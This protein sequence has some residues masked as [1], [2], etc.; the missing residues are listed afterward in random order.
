MF[1]PLRE[2]GC[3]LK[4]TVRWIQIQSLGFSDSSTSTDDEA[5]LLENKE[6]FDSQDL[7]NQP[8]SETRPSKLRL[9]F[10]ITANVVSTVSIVSILRSS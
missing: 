4:G 1:A 3:K 8:D 9:F 2:L 6:I 7:E 10:C 5:K